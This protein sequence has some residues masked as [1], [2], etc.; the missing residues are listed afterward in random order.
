[1]AGDTV[2][3]HVHLENHRH[4][5]SLVESDETPLWPSAT[6]LP[7]VLC[8]LDRNRGRL[9]WPNVETE[10]LPPSSWAVRPRL[11]IDGQSGRCSHKEVVHLKLSLLIF[12]VLQ[13]AWIPNVMLHK[14]TPAHT[15]TYAYANIHLTLYKNRHICKKKRKAITPHRMSFSKWA[16]C[17]QCENG[18]SKVALFQWLWLIAKLSLCNSYGWV[19]AYKIMFHSMKL[20]HNGGGFAR[21]RMHTII[22][23]RQLYLT[24]L[25]AIMLHNILCGITNIIG[26]SF[27]KLP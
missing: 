24:C 25:T 1:M 26:R 6:G 5:S 14:H 12:A 8:S 22:S 27:M 11:V 9:W 15:H 16:T 13:R 17:I 23:T 19:P 21:Q 10:T 20:C 2:V 3:P 18:V 7:S 4:L